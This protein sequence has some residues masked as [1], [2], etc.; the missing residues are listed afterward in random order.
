MDSIIYD[1]NFVSTAAKN[2]VSASKILWITYNLLLYCV[3]FVYNL[4]ALGYRQW[5]F[6]AS[7]VASQSLHRSEGMASNNP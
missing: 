3:S 7:A 6:M 4:F 1:K 2:F 5:F